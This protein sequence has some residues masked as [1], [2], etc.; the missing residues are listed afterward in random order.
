MNLVVFENNK[1]LVINE[2][3]A[4]RFDYVELASEVAETRF[5]EFLFG[6]HIVAKLAEH[7]P[8]PRQREHVPLWF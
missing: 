8:A 7:Y 2:F 3:R 6:K 5:F 4:G 1:P